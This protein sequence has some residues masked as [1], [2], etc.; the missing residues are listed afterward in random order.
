MKKI[1]DIILLLLA[2]LAY[3]IAVLW[4][5]IKIGNPLGFTEYE[6]N[7]TLLTAPFVVGFFI[8]LG[9]IGTNKKHHNNE[10]DEPFHDTV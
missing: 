5:Y 6:V 1:I 8:D 3:T 9:K 4:L 7:Y 10:D 2:C